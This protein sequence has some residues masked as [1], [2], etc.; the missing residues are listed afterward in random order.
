MVSSVCIFTNLYPPAFSGSSI[1]CAD[2]AKNLAERGYQVTV[3]TSR[4]TRESPEYEIINGI[5][6]YRVPSIKLPKLPIALN[7][8]WL[9]FSFSLSN[10]RRILNILRK[11][12]PDVL[13]LHNH[14]F[15]S[16]LHALIVSYHL[17]IPLVLTIH[18]IIKHTNQ[19]YD[20][21]LHIVDRFILK[22]LIVRRAKIV[23]CQDYIV[24]KYIKKTFNHPKVILIPYGITPLRKASALK[25]NSLRKKYEIEGPVILSLGHLHETRNRKE[26]LH[27]LPRLLKVYNKLKVII[28]GY[29][30]TTSTEKLAKQLGVHENIIFTGTIPHSDIPEFLDIADIEAH[31]FDKKHPHKTLGIA[32][33]EVMMAGKPLISNAPENIYGQGVLKNHENIEL[34]NPADSI[35]L[36]EK[37]SE[38]LSDKT[39]RDKIGKHAQETAENNFSWDI[40]C[41]K[42][43]ETYQEAYKSYY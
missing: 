26:L 25:A 6:I 35:L 4:L 2:L 10:I 18:T 31:W 38:L 40:I 24:E 32:G 42:L 17:R 36:F 9:N 3:I 12:R 33:Q 39:K 20:T 1:H 37:I 28:V 15:D 21:A 22:H 41:N 5:N 16:A 19:I 27:I 29:I 8:P 34:I 43:I 7:F 14:M 11:H 13:H 23:I 30:G